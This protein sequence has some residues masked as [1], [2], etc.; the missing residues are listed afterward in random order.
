MG[1]P[2][3]PTL[4]NVF[5]CHFEEQWISDCPIDY[6]PI[7][8]RRYVDDAF[9]LFSSELHV[10]KFLNYMNSKH[11]NIKFTVERE[12]NDSLSFLDIKIFRDNWKFQTL[13]YRKPTFSGVLTNFESFLPISY[14]YNLV[15]TLFHRGFMI[16]S[17]YRTL[18]FEILKLKQIFRS[19][20]Y[21]KNFIDRCIKMYL[22]K[23]FIKR[24]NICVVPRIS[25]CF[26]FS[27]QKVIGNQ[28]V[29]TKC[30]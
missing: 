13:V 6:K 24:L 4:V 1:S 20:G 27:R 11:R 15:S 30:Y 3:G 5:L 9:L 21:L 10:T 7:S 2:L 26:P 16:C 22:D 28:K 8:Y 25:L 19:N 29:T 14:K 18:H 17:S 23:V 12:E